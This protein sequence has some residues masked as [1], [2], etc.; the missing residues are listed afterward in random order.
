MEI[1]KTV[2]YKHKYPRQ[3]RFLHYKLLALKT[4]YPRQNKQNSAPK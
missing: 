2:D 1:A 4:D 3:K